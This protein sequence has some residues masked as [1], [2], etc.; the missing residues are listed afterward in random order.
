MKKLRNRIGGSVLALLLVLSLC[1]SPFVSLSVYAEDEE[2]EIKAETDASAEI[3]EPGEEIGEEPGEE[4]EEE[5]VEEPGEEPEEKSE[6]IIEAIQ[7]S[8]ECADV[9]FNNAY[10]SDPVMPASFF[11]VLEKTE[12]GTEEVEADIELSYYDEDGNALTSAPWKAGKY[13]V[14][15]TL[16]ENEEIFAECALTLVKTPLYIIL[17]DGAP[18]E[19][20]ADGNAVDFSEYFTFLFKGE[21]PVLIFKGFRGDDGYWRNDYEN[22]SD[23]YAEYEGYQPYKDMFEMHYYDA[24]GNELEKAPSEPGSYSVKASIPDLTSDNGMY[25]PYLKYSEDDN[26][27][28]EDEHYFYRYGAESE[29]VQFTIKEAAAVK[30]S[31]DDKPAV[32]DNKNSNTTDDKKVVATK[33]TEKKD[34]AKTNDTK[35]KVAAKTGDTSQATLYLILLATCGV[36]LA[37]VVQRRRRDF[38]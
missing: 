16:A 17:R 6:L 36:I 29:I 3:E 15:A 38:R 5:P 8:V 21:E 24:D 2:A 28:L 10:S 7:A 35:K 9:D 18:L 22:F 23:E 37:I 32:D 13:V 33:N 1:V 4:P 26:G 27:E 34:A 12:D 20:T 25:A 14:F 30:P 11:K 19:F 31:E